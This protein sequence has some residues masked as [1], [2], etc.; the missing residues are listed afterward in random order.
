MNIKVFSLNNSTIKKEKHEIFN[1][2]KVTKILS[3]NYAK[4]FTV[5]ILSK[6][7]RSYLDLIFEY[8]EGQKAITRVSTFSNE[9]S[10]LLDYKSKNYGNIKFDSLIGYQNY[11]TSNNEFLKGVNYLP[12][13]KIHE[14]IFN[15]EPYLRNSQVSLIDMNSL[16]KSD[17]PAKSNYSP[18]GF[19]A[20][21]ICSM[22]YFI[23]NS[24][25]NVAIIFNND[26]NDTEENL[27]VSDILIDNM[28]HYI[29]KGI[30]NRSSSNLEN[31][32]NLVY[33]NVQSNSN[34]FEFVKNTLS[35]KWWVLNNNKEWIPCSYNDYKEIVDNE[36]LS[37]YLMNNI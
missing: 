10:I 7:F 1:L 16:K 11:Y 15:A 37:D 32:N 17:F 8:I 31:E 3:K 36:N 26:I 25:N 23:G 14:D 28:I 19:T 13:G 6:D 5:L 33:Y 12:L 18:I 34:D 21:E 2:S 24:Q 35:N 9:N 22:S 30:E 4:N 29:I 27:M 20:E